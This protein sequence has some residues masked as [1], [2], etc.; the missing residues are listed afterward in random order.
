MRISDWSSDVCSSDLVGYDKVD[1]DHARAKGIRVTNTPDVLTDDVADLAV[2]L[3]YATVR[4]IAANDRPVRAG[5]WARGVQ[6][7]LSGRVSGRTIGQLSLGRIGDRTSVV[8]GNRVPD[9]L[10]IG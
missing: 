8:E 5:A 4:T 1:V 7:A 9:R 10:T 6:P 2:G 3:L